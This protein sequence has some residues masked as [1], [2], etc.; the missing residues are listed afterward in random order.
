MNNLKT[1]AR[2]CFLLR[3]YVRRLEKN[4]GCVSMST[5]Q[6]KIRVILEGSRALGKIMRYAVAGSEIP[7]P[8]ASFTN[9]NSN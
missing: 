7:S 4:L 2:I 5:L 8:I 9:N 1:V 6:V 3:S